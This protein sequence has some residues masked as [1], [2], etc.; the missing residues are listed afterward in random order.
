MCEKFPKLAPRKESEKLTLIARLVAFSTAV[1]VEI[2]KDAGA[3]S[4]NYHTRPSGIQVVKYQSIVEN[5]VRWS[6]VPEDFNRDLEVRR[7]SIK[8]RA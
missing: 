4:G 6:N 3:R 2:G 5:L 7:Q 8:M 1:F